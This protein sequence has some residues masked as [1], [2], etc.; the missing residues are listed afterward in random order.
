MIGAAGILAQQ[1]TP[2]F[3]EP[4]APLRTPPALEIDLLRQPLKFLSHET[5]LRLLQASLDPKE[6]PETDGM[7]S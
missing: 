7:L 4:A 6:G 5:G 2:R 3:R 1:A